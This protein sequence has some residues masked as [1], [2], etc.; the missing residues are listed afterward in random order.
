MRI[1][2]VTS[3]TGFATLPSTSAHGVEVPPDADE[4]YWYLTGTA[5][6]TYYYSPDGGATWYVGVSF[7]TSTDGQVLVQA[8]VGQRVAIY[9]ASGLSAVSY[10]WGNVGGRR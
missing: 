10:T 6:G 5:T 2:N 4:V 8:A 3:Y 7:D 1:G 9:A